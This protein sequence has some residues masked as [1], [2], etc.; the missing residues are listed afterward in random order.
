M[1]QFETIQ[2]RSETPGDNPLLNEVYV[3]ST[4][5]KELPANLKQAVCHA[6]TH[7]EDTATKMAGAGGFGLVL[8]Y[9]SKS[10]GKIGAIA[11]G[12]GAAAGV[13]FLA[14]GVR[15]VSQAA[16]I[17]WNGR[18]FIYDFFLSHG[19]NGHSISCC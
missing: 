1:E 14:E 2:T 15:P 11:K 17:A 13:S 5:L 19:N 8:G 4:G 6:L 16:N 12:I 3:F 18:G 7:P 9:L 10:N